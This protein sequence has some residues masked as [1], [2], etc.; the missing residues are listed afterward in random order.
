MRNVASANCVRP[1]FDDFPDLVVNFGHI[2]P[3]DGALESV[4]DDAVV[5]NGVAKI[6]VGESAVLPRSRYVAGEIQSVILSCNLAD[7]AIDVSLQSAF[8]VAE[9]EKQ[10]SGMLFVALCRK[11]RFERR[12]DDA[13]HMRHHIRFFGV[14][15]TECRRMSEF[16]LHNL[17]HN[18]HA[19]LPR[20]E[21]KRELLVF[22][23]EI[24]HFE[25]NFRKDAEATFA[26]HHDLVDIGTG[27]LSRCAVRLD[28]ADWR[29]VLL[30]KHD[31][32]RT[33]VIGGVLPGT[34]RDNP[35][36]YAGILERLRE[37]SAS[38]TLCRAE[39]FGRMIEDVFELRPADAGLNGDGLIDF[40]ESDDF[41]EVFAD[42]NHD[43]GADHRFRAARDGRSARMNINLDAVV[44]R[45]LDKAFDLRF[46]GGINDD[47]GH[48]FD[49]TFSQS[50]DVDHG[51]AV[52]KAHSFKVV[53]GC[54][55]GADDNR[56]CL[57]LL[58]CER[59]FNVHVN[60][61]FAR[62]DHDFEIVVA[63]REYAFDEFV[64]TFF[65]GF[66]LVGIAPFHDGTEGSGIGCFGDPF[67]FVVFVGF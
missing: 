14:R 17:S 25:R 37:V 51:F 6:R 56:D 45:I 61:L 47:V 53:C 28:Y 40:V 48:V 34:S 41:V 10:A 21:H 55:V 24:E 62:V 44:V 5:L 8:A 54:V 67:G 42:V 35:A 29:D 13:V 18:R 63:Q 65:G 39:I 4:D 2:V 23:G 20:R 16:T 1:C 3:V 50:H 33:A 60:K 43:V 52:C 49:D 30:F 7:V 12:T 32:R 57:D 38:V 66:I 59:A 22:F 58:L 11:K 36:A 31:V 46:V 9:A 19:V 15:K 64:K 26:A 27:C